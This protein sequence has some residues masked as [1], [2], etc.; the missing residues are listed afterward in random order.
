MDGTGWF[1]GSLQK[2]QILEA[3]S[4]TP[5]TL[6]TYRLLSLFSLPWQAS[7]EVAGGGG[8]QC[9]LVWLSNSRTR[10]GPLSPRGRVT[11]RGMLTWE[12]NALGSGFPFL[13]SGMQLEWEVDPRLVLWA[14]LFSLLWQQPSLSPHL[15]MQLRGHLGHRV[16]NNYIFPTVSP[17]LSHCPSIPGQLAGV[18]L[19]VTSWEEMKHRAHTVQLALLEFYGLR[20]QAQNQLPNMWFWPFTFHV[21]HL[22][23]SFPEKIPGRIGDGA[24]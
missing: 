15:Q 9:E 5:S 19:G 23:F 20:P 16:G 24:G 12:W 17:S 6:F 10:R 8:A 7:P 18:G 1:R 22:Y 21:V 2:P 3:P 13:L 11:V 14:A 4:S